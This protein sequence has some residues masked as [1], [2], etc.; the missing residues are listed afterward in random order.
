[1]MNFHSHRVTRL[2]V[3]EWMK[4][5]IG[6]RL[7]RKEV[8]TVFVMVF[9]VFLRLFARRGKMIGVSRV[10]RVSSINVFRTIDWSITFTWI[11]TK[12]S[13]S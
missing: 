7:S 5:V 12:M 9:G 6:I 13:G 8:L 11:C 4:M 10:V 2:S 1:M 3:P